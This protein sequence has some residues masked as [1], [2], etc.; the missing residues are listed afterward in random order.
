MANQK[1]LAGDTLSYR[2]NA[3]I[4]QF[5]F[6]LLVTAA[7]SVTQ[8]AAQGVRASGVS[9]EA[10]TVAGQ[11]IA[12]AVRPGCVTKMTAAGVIPVGGL[13][14]PAADGR[15]EVAAAADFICGVNVDVAT[16][17]NQI[18][19]MLLRWDGVL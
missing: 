12:V 8:V 1:L 11:E 4:A 17:A 5:R 13:C 9:Q 2:A 15:A 14:T 6:V 10:A 18:F 19:S 3:A 7:R 16:V